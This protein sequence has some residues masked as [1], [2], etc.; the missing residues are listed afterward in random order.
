MTN[1]EAQ[2]K[3]LQTL[4]AIEDAKR[5]DHGDI[6]ALIIEDELADLIRDL[7]MLLVDVAQWRP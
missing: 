1:Q 4:E 3:F 7:P 5:V 2:E 6:S